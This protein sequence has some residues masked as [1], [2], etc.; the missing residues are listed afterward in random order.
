VEAMWDCDVGE[1]SAQATV[2]SKFFPHLC[3]S[4][5]P[6]ALPNDTDLRSL[7]F[8]LVPPFFLWQHAGS[9]NSTADLQ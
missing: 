6:S 2:H 5:L 3:S 7:I 1:S 8:L 9:K 4:V